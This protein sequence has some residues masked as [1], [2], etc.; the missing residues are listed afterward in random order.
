MENTCNIMRQRKREYRILS[1]YTVS[2]MI[3]PTQTNAFTN[4]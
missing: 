4:L 3:D 1:K 2:V